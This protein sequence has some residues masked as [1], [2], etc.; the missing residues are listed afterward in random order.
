MRTYTEN[1]N[2]YCYMKEA[3]LK[4][5]YSVSLQLFGILIKAN[6]IDRKM[7]SGRSKMATR[8]WKQIAE[9]L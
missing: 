9:V 4:M 6:Y 8:V 2:E 5:S 7:V 3:I 1:L